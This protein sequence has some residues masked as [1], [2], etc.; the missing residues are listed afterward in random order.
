[1][2]LT[3]GDVL[4]KKNIP[5]PGQVELIIAQNAQNA[6]NETSY[7]TSLPDVEKIHIKKVL[8]AVKWNKMETTRILQITRPTLNKKIEKYGLVRKKK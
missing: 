5:S 7:L 2:F 4:E 3:H 8:D 6:H 1:M